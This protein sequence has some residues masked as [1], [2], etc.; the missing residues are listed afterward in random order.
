MCQY[1]VEILTGE[2]WHRVKKYKI[3]EN[4]EK[5]MLAC[6]HEGVNARII[7]VKK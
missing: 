2:K 6:H 5:Y 3:F 7:E 4:A 1:E